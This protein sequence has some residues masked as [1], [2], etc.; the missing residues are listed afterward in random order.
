MSGLSTKILSPVN[1]QK[2]AFLI[3]SALS[4]TKFLIGNQSGLANKIANS[5][6]DS[7]PL[8]YISKKRVPNY[9]GHIPLSS[10]EKFALFTSSAIKSFFH[11][12]DGMN[13]VNLG[14]STAIT[15]FL[16]RLTNTM[17][18]DP[19]GRQIIRERPNISEN[20]ISMEKLATYP[21]NSLGYTFYH[22]CRTENVTPDTRAEV[23]YIDDPLHAFVFKRYRQC[24]DF[25]HA[26][27]NMPIII[28]GEI[29]IKAL[30]G[31][32]LGVPMAIMGGLFAPLRLKASQRKRLREIYIPWALKTGWTCK[33][34]INVYWEKN[35]D[36]DINEI[37][38]E[39]GIELPPNLRELRK[40]QRE[41][42]KAINSLNS[43]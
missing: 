42:R 7:I 37:R 10:T 25:Y 15:P 3:A 23:K 39:L 38:K 24:H 6:L 28:E 1:L 20:E 33:P 29:T 36:K 5:E 11:P 22:W 35:L 41:E 27:V 21:K 32:N 31:A 40:K 17:L 8:E 18:S 43:K 13:I 14:E 16:D 19:V 9:P 4:L 2:N 12:E 30:E 34:L 26:L